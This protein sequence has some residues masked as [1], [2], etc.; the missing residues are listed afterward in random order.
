MSDE[1]PSSGRE[2]IKFDEFKVY[3][4]VICADDD[5]AM[6]A[7]IY[8][9][10]KVIDYVELVFK[11]SSKDDKEGQKEWWKAFLLYFCA[12]LNMAYV[13]GVYFNKNK[14]VTHSPESYEALTELFENW[15]SKHQ[16]LNENK[17]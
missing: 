2:I 11:V 15:K 3:D 17:E 16:G 8:R 13:K 6:Y 1:T 5:P 7:I 14:I 9:D 10:P 4:V 12:H